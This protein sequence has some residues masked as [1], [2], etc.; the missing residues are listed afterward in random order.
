MLCPE[1]S[2]GVWL[3]VRG[4]CPGVGR[5]GRP[6]MRLK[7]RYQVGVLTVGVT[8]QQERRVGPGTVL[9]EALW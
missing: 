4:A 9:S 1:G 8:V 5:A 7:M 6:E 3:V 2:Q